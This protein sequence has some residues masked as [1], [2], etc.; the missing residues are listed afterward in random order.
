MGKYNIPITWESYKRIEVE[1][2]NLEGAILKA[3][4]QFFSEPD[5]YYIEDSFNV[6]SIIYDEFPQEGFSMNRIWE[7]L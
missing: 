2:D 7:Q 3:L 4:K 6:D 5:E 1:A